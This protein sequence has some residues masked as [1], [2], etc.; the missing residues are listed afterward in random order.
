MSERKRTLEDLQSFCDHWWN[1]SG[2]LE[3]EFPG[4]ENSRGWDVFKQ[5]Y[6]TQEN[7]INRLDGYART[8]AFYISPELIILRDLAEIASGKDNDLRYQDHR[9]LSRSEAG[10]K[11]GD[12]V[13]FLLS[14]EG[15]DEFRNLSDG[16]K[17]EAKKREPNYRGAESNVADLVFAFLRYVRRERSL[18]SKKALKI[19]AHRIQH[20]LSKTDPRWN[21]EGRWADGEASPYIKKAGLGKLAKGG[22]RSK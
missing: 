2:G 11:L 1:T 13:L 21:D 19:E 12:R 4:I 5:E 6:D 17:E 20:Q 15:R 3:R 8:L 10:I 22:G 7:Q 14:P 16:L 18:P 9:S